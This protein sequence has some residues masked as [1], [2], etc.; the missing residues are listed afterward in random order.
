M[1]LYDRSALTVS[2]VERTIM[3]GTSGIRR[4]PVL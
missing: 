3:V 1:D 2:W 4:D